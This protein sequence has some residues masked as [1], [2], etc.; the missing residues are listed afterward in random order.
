VPLLQLNVFFQSLIHSSMASYEQGTLHLCRRQK[1]KFIKG[2]RNITLHFTPDSSLFLMIIGDGYHLTVENPLLICDSSLN[3]VGLGI[4][5]AL[6]M[7]VLE[8]CDV[9]DNN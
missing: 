7:I 6:L 3:T 5:Y 2:Q 8:L 4:L 1:N 9:A